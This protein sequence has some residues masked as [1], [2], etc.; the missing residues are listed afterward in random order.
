MRCCLICHRLLREPAT[1]R[2]PLYCGP[3]HR[4]EAEYLRRT[5]KRRRF[6]AD[7]WGRWADAAE[8][9]GSAYAADYRRTADGFAAEAAKLE[10]R[11]N[12]G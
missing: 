3:E 4:R 1:G 9:T 7:Q 6:R 11:L 10:A 8:K 5:A 2:K 12:P